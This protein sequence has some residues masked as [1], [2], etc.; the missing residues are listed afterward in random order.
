MRI[1]KF[2]A[3]LGLAIPGFVFCTSHLDENSPEEFYDEEELSHDMIILG[4]QLQ[5]PYSVK[6]ITKA[7]EN[8]YPTKAMRE[9]VMP[10][11]MYVRFLPENEQEYDR[12]M[13]MGMFLLDHP[14]D[15]QILRDGDYYHDPLIPED[16]IT[17]QYAVLPV[18]FDLPEDIRYEILDE[19]YIPKETTK[20]DGLDWERIE[21]ESYRI[22]GNEE[23]LQPNTKSTDGRPSGRITIV[24]DEANGGKPFGLAG[25]T[26]V[27]NSFVKF[28]TATTDRDGYYEIDKNYSSKLR[29]RI[30]FKNE[31]GFAIGFNKLLV[32][33]SMSTLGKSGPE[34]VDYT[35]DK[36]S[37]RKLFSR[38]V[39]NNTVYDYYERCSGN[40]M[41]ISSPPSDLRIWL[42]QKLSASSCPM[43]R[44]G[45]MLDEGILSD[46]LGNYVELVK[47][48]LP[49]V[50][51]GL[52][53]DETYSEIYATVCHELAH[54]SHYTKVGNQ[55]WTQYLKYQLVSFAKRNG[56]DYGSGSGIGAGHCAVSEMWAYFLQNQLY[57]SRYGGSIPNS[58][59]SHWFHPQIFTYLNDR[60]M[61]VSQLFQAL[62][63]DVCDMENLHNSL[64]TLY[65]SQSAMINQV[66]MRYVEED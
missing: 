17:W 19:C 11:D 45:A 32:S 27:C 54:A 56:I 31:K 28:S 65:P 34:G 14:L 15:Y 6:N 42:F 58:G 64:L 66:F 61:T 47:V 10:T 46:Y 55:F 52:K 48:F 1:F 13:S 26:I 36:N 33:A 5:D 7:I 40:Y 3:V 60:G 9:D 41:N 59:M 44:H 24:D 12:L 21:Q 25:V 62:Q 39:V 16:K 8:L 43:L 63:R 30:M 20:A 23:L 50:M 29:Y 4:E 2:I 18:D 22:T 49:D 51:L 38:A 57:Y 53:G 37:D 35:I